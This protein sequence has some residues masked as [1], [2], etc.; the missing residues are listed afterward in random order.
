MTSGPEGGVLPML[1]CIDIIK[2]EGLLIRHIG[3]QIHHLSTFGRHFLRHLRRV[4]FFFSGLPAQPT[5]LPG[6]PGRRS[7]SP[8]PGHEF[9]GRVEQRS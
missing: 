7:G 8:L 9:K 3:T 2:I 6:V 4:N 1:H 5:Y